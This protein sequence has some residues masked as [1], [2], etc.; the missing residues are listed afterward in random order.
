[1]VKTNAARKCPF[2][3]LVPIARFHTVRA[4]VRVRVLWD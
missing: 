1:M 2:T 4:W 3:N